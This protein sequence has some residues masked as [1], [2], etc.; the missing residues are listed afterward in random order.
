M[1]SNNAKYND[2]KRIS[3]DNNDNDNNNDYIHTDRYIYIYMTPA[4]S[5]HGPLYHTIVSA[6][7]KR[8][9]SPTGT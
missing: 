8:V 6:P 2:A 1:N 7:A 5:H 4:S 3:N 9:L